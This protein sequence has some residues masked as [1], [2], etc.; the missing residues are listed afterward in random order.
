MDWYVLSIFQKVPCAAEKNAYSLA[1]RQTLCRH[2]LVQR[3]GSTLVFFNF[4]L[5][6]SVSLWKS[7]TEVT[8]YKHICIYLIFHIL[9]YLFY[10]DR[11]PGN[12]CIYIN[13]RSNCRIVPLSS[14]LYLSLPCHQFQ[15]QVYF[16]WEQTCYPWWLWGVLRYEILFFIVKVLVYEIFWLASKMEDCW[17]PF[18][19]PVCQFVA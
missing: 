1:V 16:L 19:D 3:C 10:E 13:T 18:I 7:G 6:R 4:L 2:S 8:H 12:G 14:I 17:A 11:C 5:G 15:L 9:H